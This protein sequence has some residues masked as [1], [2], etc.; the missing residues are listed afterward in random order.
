MH[1][2]LCSSRKSSTPLPIDDVFGK[3]LHVAPHI[4]IHRVSLHKH[5]FRTVMWYV[6]IT[7]TTMFTPSLFDDNVNNDNTTISGRRMSKQ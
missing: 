6:L 4:Y 3:Q 5:L 1:S 7:S 2:H